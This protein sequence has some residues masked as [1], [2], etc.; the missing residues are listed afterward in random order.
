VATPLLQTKL[1]IPSP[2][3]EL[4]ARPRLIDRLNAG[5]GNSLGFARKLT[6]ASA[7]AGFGKTTLVSEWVQALGRATVPIA[8][9]W[10]SLDE[11]DNDPTRFLTYLIA[12][13][14][15]ALQTS[16]TE[17]GQGALSALQSTQPPPAEGILTTLIN[18][19][20]AISD[21]I[22]FVLD[23]YHLIDAQPIHDALAFLLRRLPSRL[24][25]VISTREDPP[26]PLARLRARGQLTELR[27]TDLRFTSSE[28]AAFLNQAMGLDLSAEDVAALERRTEGW[29]AGLQ[30]AA[31]SMQGRKDVAGF[32]QSFTGSH[33]YVL[34][35]LVEEVLEQQSESVQAFLLQTSILDRLTGPLC[36][37]VC[38]GTAETPS[39]SEGTALTDQGDGQA[40]LEMLE[41]ANLFVIPLDEER[42]WYRYHHL[43]ADLLR[44]RLWQSPPP[45]LSSPTGGPIAE[46]QRRASVWYEENGFIDEAIEHT[47]RAEDFE[48]AATLIEE[49]V[50]AIWQRGEH[51]KSRRWL[52]RLPLE[53]V[54]AKPHLCVLHAWD[55]FAGGQQDA[56]EQSLQAAERALDASADHTTETSSMERDQLPGSK[57]MQI[58]G[59]AAAIRA[60]L[61]FYRGDVQAIQKYSRQALEYLPKQDLTWRSA[62]T[63]AL[64]D[65]YSFVGDMPAAYRVRLEALEASKAA[66]NTY[67]TLIASMKLAVTM[68]Q[69]GRLDHVIEICQQQMQ[70]ASKSGLSQTAVAGGLLAVWGEILA[71]SND[72][73]GAIHQAK[74]G[75]ELTERG[76][77]VAML[78]WSYLCLTRVLFTRGDMSGAEAVIQRVENTAREHDLPPWIVSLMATWQARIWLAQD[79]LDAA[80][81][82]VA[83]RELDTDGD[84]T[85]MNEKEYMVLA[86]IL[87]AQGRLDEATTLLQRLLEATETG[88]R[89]S[90]VIEVLLL[91]ALAFQAGGNTDQAITALGRA[92]TLAEPGG[93]IRV[94]ADEG[95]PMARLLY[96]A[97]TRGIAPDYVR[98]LL[99]A[100]PLAQ[101][102]PAADSEQA[103][104]LETQGSKSDLIEPLSERE[105]EVLELVAE[106][107]TNQEIASR[108]FLSQHTIKA[109]TRNIYGKLGVHNRT[110]AVARCRALGI[111]PSS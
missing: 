46:L 31:I 104:P 9:A 96:E 20:A 44:Q 82:W 24:H 106:G 29:I 83:E 6:L 16:E 39:S 66:G 11:S 15:T 77:D 111:L 8:I 45:F 47:L 32:I 40:T 103:T 71:E 97:L 55:L 2:R 41:R 73:D 102:E 4:V 101:P 36:D 76:G 54:F 43:F 12:A 74:K 87:I 25:L 79:M 110:E 61:A 89:T 13:L 70:L 50:D 56:A 58:Q 22:V 26:L 48:R 107:L 91:Q 65:A 90:R 14:Q 81:R 88:G 37:T 3:P 59:R 38:F 10:L 23:D 19:I 84:P 34:D 95:P 33:H 63:V 1:H 99:A 57:E 18:E 7:P 21:Q 53:L 85:S 69:R 60:F 28:A 5:L 92:F 100:F 93:Y 67:M 80:S 64:G 94:F 49:N 30:L 109:H 52:A 108:L 17:I 42:R 27:A 86:R 98:R 105:A 72:L 35:Y 75:T 68:R 78:G 62:A 51:I